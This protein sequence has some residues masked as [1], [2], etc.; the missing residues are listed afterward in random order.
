MHGLDD[1]ALHAKLPQHPLG[2][3]AYPPQAGGGLAG[4]SQP[5]QL[6]QPL[7]LDAAMEAGDGV[8][9]PLGEPQV[10]A[11]FRASPLQLEQFPV[12]AGEAL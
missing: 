5:L 6:A 7:L 2:L 9:V 12:D 3:L 4:K 1:V 8:F 10:E 11:F